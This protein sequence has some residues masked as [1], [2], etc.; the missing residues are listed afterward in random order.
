MNLSRP[1]RPRRAIESMRVLVYALAALLLAPV[2]SARAANAPLGAEVWIGLVPGSVP[3]PRE[4]YASTGNGNRVKRTFAFGGNGTLASPF[5]ASLT[6]QNTNGL[7]DVVLWLKLSHFDPAN[8]STANV[9]QG[10]TMHLMSGTYVTPTVKLDFSANWKLVGEGIDKTVIQLKPDPNGSG[11]VW[12]LRA[13]SGATGNVNKYLYVADLTLDCNYQNNLKFT[14]DHALVVSAMGGM[15][16][17]VKAINYG[18]MGGP[19]PIFQEMFPIWYCVP[20]SGNPY[21][22]IQNCE[23]TGAVVGP[24]GDAKH[25]C[26]AITVSEGAI[27]QPGRNACVI[28]S[29]NRVV[30]L[31]NG[32]A[33]NATINGTS[34]SAT[35]ILE[36]NL[37]LGCGCA[38]NCD[39]WTNSDIVIQNNH[40]KNCGIGIQI[41]NSTPGTW[42]SRFQILNN[43]I[44]VSGVQPSWEPFGIQLNGHTTSFVVSGNIITAANTLDP[45]WK[46]FYG[47]RLAG[48]Q[49]TGHIIQRNIVAPSFANVGQPSEIALAVDNLTGNGAPLRGLPAVR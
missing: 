10:F 16:E 1:S 28:I 41:G 37:A 36:D 13:G 15:V 19:N 44:E 42:F 31:P 40:F 7:S 25:Y 39:S 30:D 3:T 45:R 12:V 11:E 32:I 17:R 2:P 26:S 38:F 35:V 47:I 23:V 6:E 24:P 27:P 8:P 34:G 20:A 21:F 5:D 18:S 48:K 9:S 43:L 14:K 29:H 49:N 33:Y 22:S 4:A 46:T